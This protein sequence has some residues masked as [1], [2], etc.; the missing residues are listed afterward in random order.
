MRTVDFRKDFP[1][2]NGSTND[3]LIY[4]KSSLS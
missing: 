2:L 3:G 1:L 4:I